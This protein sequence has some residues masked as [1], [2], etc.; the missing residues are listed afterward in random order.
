[1]SKY[2]KIASVQ[3]NTDHIRGDVGVQ[4]KTLEKLARSL[5]SL[6]GYGINL[7]TTSEWL[8]AQAQEIWQAETIVSPGPFLKLYQSFAAAEKCHVAG[9][10]KLRKDDKVYNSIAFIDDTGK[11][12]GHY[13]KTFLHWPE[14]DEGLEPGSGPVVVDTA[15]GRLGGSI[16]FDLNF[17]ELMNSYKKHH[18][19]IMVF[20][21]MYHGG[22]MQAQWAYQLRSFFVSAL[23]RYGCG[24]LDP[25]GR[26]VRL[27]DC[28]SPVACA[29][30]NLDRVM[31]HLDCNQE[32]FPDIQRKYGDEVSIDIP[33]DIGS[34][35][36]Y[37]TVTQRTA[38]DIAREFGLILLDDYFVQGIKRNADKRTFAIILG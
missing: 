15:I 8:E 25:F 4:E 5:D 9:S 18:P 20:S 19:D 33:A 27:T 29:T 17:T 28:Y 30:V 11:I 10:V 24:I 36:I 2:V 14:V 34:A 12:I 26:P 1:M 31:V 23:P 32:K 6:K 37:S 38:M 16:C 7:V 22:L 3:A 21:S 35:L 13:D